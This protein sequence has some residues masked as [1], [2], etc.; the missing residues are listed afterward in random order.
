M[1]SPRTETNAAFR[2]AIKG[3]ALS[4]LLSSLILPVA[5]Q[6]KPK[7]KAPEPTVP[8]VFTLMGQFVRVAYNNEG[9]V[10][11]GYRTAQASVGNEWMLLEVGL[12]VRDGA[13]TEVLKRDAF[14]V[15]T[16]DGA[17]QPL[18]TQQQ[19]GTGELRGL[20]LLANHSRDTI[21]YFPGAISRRCAISFFSDPDKKNL[22]YD[23]VELNSQSGCLGRLYFHIPG[24]IKT[25][26][27]WLKVKFANGEVHVP[28]R[29][30]TKEEEKE[31]R[32]TWED[33]KDEH[34]ASTKAKQKP[35]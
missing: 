18:A 11:L 34:D 32:K 5:A 24:G 33:L 6:D 21:S 7:P 9:Y 13:D 22:T 4:A 10:T 3:L 35:K 12:T 31:F 20:Q 29:I 17:T 19:Y 14:S 15:Q 2:S 16:P 25:G 8:E 23:Q 26:Q 30:L 28:F 27:H 1:S